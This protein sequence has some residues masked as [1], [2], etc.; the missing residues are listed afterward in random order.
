MKKTLIASVNLLHSI[1]VINVLFGWIYLTEIY[2]FFVLGVLLIQK[3]NEGRC[4]LTDL[5]WYLRGHW[6][7]WKHKGWFAWQFGRVGIKI[8][9]SSANRLLSYASVF[10][11]GFAIAKIF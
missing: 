5:E 11:I 3:S 1:L 2:V 8:S 9:E 10:G 6:P 4:P 7:T